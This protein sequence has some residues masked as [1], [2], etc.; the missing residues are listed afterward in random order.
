MIIRTVSGQLLVELDWSAEHLPGE[1]RFSGVLSFGTMHPQPLYRWLR[2]WPLWFSWNEDEAIDPSD[3]PSI[4]DVPAV[5]DYSDNPGYQRFIRSLANDMDL[6][7]DA[8]QAAYEAWA[9]D[10]ESPDY[11]G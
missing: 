9:T 5:D 8:A 4:E 6:D 11:H 10:Q 2:V 7:Y 1:G 3:P